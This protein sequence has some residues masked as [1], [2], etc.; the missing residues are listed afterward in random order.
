VTE[1][2]ESAQTGASDSAGEGVVV[3][4]PVYKWALKV[5]K[6]AE[7]AGNAESGRH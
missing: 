3:D 2:G 5:L 4:L 6:R 1:S 7:M